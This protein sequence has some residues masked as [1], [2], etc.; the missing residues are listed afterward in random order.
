MLAIA[1]RALPRFV[2]AVFTGD[3]ISLGSND[4]L[5]H[6]RYAENIA[7]SFPAWG[8]FDPFL[9]PDGGSVPVSPLLAW[10]A[11]ALSLPFGHLDVIAIVLPPLFG[12]AAVVALFFLLRRSSGDAT[13]FIGAI[14]LAVL[15]GEFLGRSIVGAFDHH[16]L[17]VLLFVATLALLVAA[18]EREQRAPAIASGVALALYCLAWSSAAMGVVL[19]IGIAA[20]TIAVTSCAREL[21]V[22]FATA[23]LLVAP[24]TTLLPR[25]TMTLALLI[26]ATLF[27]AVA[28]RFGRVAAFAACFAATIVAAVAAPRAAHLLH[29]YASLFLPGSMS[30]TVTEGQS[31]LN[32]D[33]WRIAANEVGLA[34]VAAVAGVAI[35]V[36]NIRRER[37]AADVIVLAAPL[38][39]AAAA[40]AQRRFLYYAAVAVAIL[41]AVALAKLR[42]RTRVVATLIVVAS[43]ALSARW[44]APPERDMPPAI[45]E[46]AAY[47]R[48]QTPDPFDAG[49]VYFRRFTDANAAP[50]A[51]YS[52]LAWWDYGYALMHDARRVPSAVPTQAGARDT[53]AFLLAQDESAAAPFAARMRVRY[54]V[55]DSSLMILRPHGN[56]ASIGGYIAQVAAWNR[57]PASRYFEQV[58]YAPPGE[59]ERLVYLFHP[60]YYRSMAARMYLFGGRGARP[61]YTVA[62]LAQSGASKRLVAL[63]PYT[64]YRDAMNA[65]LL[66]PTRSKRLVGT[67][68][69]QSCV[70]VEPL[71]QYREVF[72]SSSTEPDAGGR[73]RVRVFERMT[74]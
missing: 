6:L 1:V 34:I 27:A 53:A 54:A 59:A 24:F 68:P 28:I 58:L 55:V 29:G 4:A 15:P 43:L 56:A 74:P 52:V 26:I 32:A 31:L 60:E 46:T 64:R 69:L 21:F 66:D 30:R 10:I 14:L 48:A 7:A 51:K 71:T 18:I 38:L 23:T 72:T 5:Y 41:A 33:V 12:A 45:R 63:T 44:S 70:P 49:D 73:P 20:A 37:R 11:A 67:D 35:L 50:R 16:V 2:R 22:M 25:G 65:V 13:A 57:E 19:L 39:L 17:E 61:L 42:G 62:T 3:A 9:R 36:R 47:L 8:T 40:I